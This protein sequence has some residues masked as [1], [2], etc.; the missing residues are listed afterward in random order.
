MQKRAT[1]LSDKEEGKHLCRHENNKSNTEISK[2]N[3]G[4]GY[5]CV[6]KILE[7]DR[8]YRHGAVPKQKLN[9][10]TKRQSVRN[11]SERS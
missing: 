3:I 10:R 7:G 8:P 5:K 11:L 4:R 9:E 1:L 6:T 2:K